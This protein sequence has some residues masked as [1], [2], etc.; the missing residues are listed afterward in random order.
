[1]STMAYPLLLHTKT[2]QMKKI[3]PFALLWVL[4]GT[5]VFSQKFDLTIPVDGKLREFIVVRPS[6]PV[7]TGG[8]PVVFMLHG[9]S[10]DG[11]RFYNNSGW[12]EV[13]E[14]EKFITVFPSSLKY[15]IEEKGIQHMTTRWNNGGLIS[16][17]CPGQDF[18]DDVRFF[19][20]MIDTLIESLPINRSM[21]YVSGFSNGG[22]MAAK[23]ATVMGDVFAAATCNSAGLHDLDSL[24]VQNKIPVW[25]MFGDVDSMFIEATGKSYIPFN[26]SCLFFR[27]NIIENYLGSFGLDRIYTKDSTAF[28]LSYTFTTALPNE[29]PTL[30]RFTLA[31]GLGHVFPNGSNYPVRIASVYWQF[32]KNF[33]KSTGTFSTKK[34]D[35]FEISPNPVQDEITINTDTKIKL[36]EVYNTLGQL[37]L[38]VQSPA[39][40]T[41]NL[42][43]LP[44]NYYIMTII[45][46]EGTKI[47][48]FLKK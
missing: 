14:E 39:S 21:I 48:K 20:R 32:F 42:A 44:S 3:I 30:F 6:G 12:K 45:T 8:Y 41:I 4:Y 26:D 29:A 10:D 11:E 24:D 1:M 37:M 40:P 36:I 19:R 46:Q 28:S 23:L 35:A 18:K 47:A 27:A 13:G 22:Q 25:D 31:K 38:Q 7:P 33:R 15:C 17:A 16:E 5:L 34:I 43:S 2:I 9:T